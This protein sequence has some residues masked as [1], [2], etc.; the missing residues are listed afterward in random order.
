MIDKKNLIPKLPENK[1]IQLSDG[2]T[3]GYTEWGPIAGNPVLFF[4]G[5]PGTRHCR[6]GTEDLVSKVDIRL[7]SLDRPGYGLSDPKPGRTIVDW[8]DD[9]LEFANSLGFE[10][11]AVIGHSGGGPFAAACAYKIPDRALVSVLAGSADAFTEPEVFEQLDKETQG[12]IHLS[13][14]DPEE[15][16][17]I[18]QTAPHLTVEALLNR[19]TTTGPAVDIDVHKEPEFLAMLKEILDEAITSVGLEKSEF[20]NEIVLLSRPWG[21]PLSKIK[22]EVHLWYGDLDDHHSPNHCRYLARV[23]PNNK[24]FFRND[25]GGMILWTCTEE[26]L[27]N[28]RKSLK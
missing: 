28:I 23:L 26:V 22:G 14:S 20:F 2:R 10:K 24:T 6:F 13:Q 12:M 7:F 3:L 18:A 21:F 15:A 5:T 16:R 8:T 19:V 9:V 4:P 17:R 25:Q 11:F 1:T 27:L